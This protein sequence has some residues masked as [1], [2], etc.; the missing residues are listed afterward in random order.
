MAEVEEICDNVTIMR[1]GTV[2]YHGSIAA[3]RKQRPR[4]AHGIRTT[5]DDRRRAAAAARGLAVSRLDHGGGRPR[6][7]P[8]IDR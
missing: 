2:V 5:D 1:T 8:D 4:K 6:T 7:Q 3:L